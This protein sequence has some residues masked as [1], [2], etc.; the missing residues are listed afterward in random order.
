MCV[1]TRHSG[2]I[3]GRNSIGVS[4]IHPKDSM[5]LNWPSTIPQ[6]TWV[7]HNYSETVSRTDQT[8]AQ[9]SAHWRHSSVVEH[10]PRQH[11]ALTPITSISENKRKGEM[12]WE[13]WGGVGV[14]GWG[15]DKRRRKGGSWKKRWKGEKDG[16]EKQ[17]E[18][19]TKTERERE[20]LMER[21]D[22]ERE[23]REDL[24]NNSFPTMHEPII[25]S[26][27]PGL[28][29]FWISNRSHDRLK[30]LILCC[31]ISTEV[32][33]NSTFLKYFHVC[34]FACRFCSCWFLLL[35]G[36]LYSWLPWSSICKPGWA[37]THKDPLTSTSHMLGLKE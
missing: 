23:E 11:R 33:V 16:K 35:T 28:F 22:G 2:R 1:W 25:W 31:P 18:Y 30:R 37:W 20:Y 34:L 6:D 24:M 10:L 29:A 26:S 3:P 17:R 14:R 4:Q 32:S 5:F 36:S 9:A 12:G 27:E 7:F 19:L 15:G 13:Q 8:R 21:E